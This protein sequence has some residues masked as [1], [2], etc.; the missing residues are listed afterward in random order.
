MFDTSLC[1]WLDMIFKW[2]K[3][4]WV[5]VWALSMLYA[6]LSMSYQTLHLKMFDPLN[7]RFFF[8]FFF[9]DDGGATRRLAQSAIANMPEWAQ[10]M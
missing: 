10:R 6:F 3:K 4:K 8:L 5:W 7:G 2:K 1:F 9:Y